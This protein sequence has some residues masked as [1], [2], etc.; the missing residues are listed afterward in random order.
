MKRVGYVFSMGPTNSSRARRFRYSA[1]AALGAVVVAVA[2]SAP[3]SALAASNDATAGSVESSLNRVESLD[4][5]LLLEPRGTDAASVIG[6][7]AQLGSGTVQVPSDLTEGVQIISENDKSVIVSLPFDE[8]ADNA[9]ALDNG[10][11]A[12]PGKDSSN[13]VIVSEVGVQMLTTIENKSAPTRFDYEVG[14][15][16]GQKLTFLNGD[17]VIL[18]A[19]GSVEL[20]VAPAWAVD[21]NGSAIPTAYEIDG[22]TLTQVV[23]HVDASTAYPVVA[24]PVWIAPWVFKCLLGLGLSGPQIT[25]AFA[26]GTIWGGLGRAAL[27]C[28]TGK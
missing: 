5:T 10:A 13:A 6:V 20:S 26:S 23:N 15:E 3:V 28:V 4:S 11:I 24:D 2:S 12:F 22:S 16:E 14:L 19:D 1:I 8:D 25:A 9:V 17:V 18:N 7:S 21:A 27:A